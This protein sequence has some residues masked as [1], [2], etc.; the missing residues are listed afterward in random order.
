MDCFYCL[1]VW[2][3]APFA[4]YAS[5]RPREAPLTWL[6]LSAPRPPEQATRE[7]AAPTDEKGDHDGMRMWARSG[8][9]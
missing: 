6:A 2:V 7:R 5:R 1:S 8:R 3:A 9:C 4:L